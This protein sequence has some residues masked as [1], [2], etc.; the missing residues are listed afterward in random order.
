MN[1]RVDVLYNYLPVRISACLDWLSLLALGIF[2]AL[3]TFYCFEVTSTSMLR[4]ATANTPLNTP[5]W[6]PQTMWFLGFVWMSV[7][8]ALLFLRASYALVTG[9]ISTLK[10]LCGARHVEEDAQAEVSYGEKIIAQ[11]TIVRSAS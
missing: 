11:S 7:V 1:V 3:L 8:L 9:D 6:I 5:L 4:H 2:F 10:K